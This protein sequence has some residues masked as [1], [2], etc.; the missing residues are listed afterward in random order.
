MSIFFCF[1][2]VFVLLFCFC[3][4]FCFCFVFVFVFFFSFQFGILHFFQIRDTSKRYWNFQIKKNNYPNKN[5]LSTDNTHLRD[6]S[7]NLSSML[8]LFKFFP[9]LRMG[10]IRC[11]QIRCRGKCLL[12]ISR[13]DRII[14]H[15]AQNKILCTEQ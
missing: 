6:M 13:K 10:T 8:L 12:R 11:E 3:F 7:F 2:F 4:C 1:V 9:T 5:I 15:Y 14:D